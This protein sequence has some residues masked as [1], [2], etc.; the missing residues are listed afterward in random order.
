M[1]QA[2]GRWT[3]TVAI[4]CALLA[5]PAIGR[6][7]TAAPG[8]QITAKGGLVQSTLDYSGDREFFERATDSAVGLAVS[9]RRLGLFGVSLQTEALYVRKGAKDAIAPR[10]RLIL[11]WI[12][13]PI[14][15]RVAA[16]RAGGVEFFGVVGPA[17]DWQVRAR[18]AGF[19]VADQYE[20][21]AMNLVAGGGASFGRWTVEA[22]GSWGFTNLPKGFMTDTLKDRSV[23]V[24]GGFRLR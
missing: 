12:E 10:D 2:I 22:R 16:G 1:T 3:R 8:L 23:F 13:V 15:A 20:S 5:L 24:L 17:V 18:F 9:F 11:E 14:L 6:A 19:D 4:A 7:Q 21:L